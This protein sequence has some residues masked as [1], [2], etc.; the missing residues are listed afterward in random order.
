MNLRR[1]YLIGIGAIVVQLLFTAWGFAQVGFDAQVPTHWGADGQ[2]NGYGAAWW[3]FTLAPAISAG[4][5]LMFG[6]IP[7]IE[8]RRENLRLSASAYRQIGVATVALM[9]LLQAGLIL[10]GTGREVPMTLL[11]GIGIGGLFMETHPDPANAM[12]DGPNAVP[13][14]HMRALLEQLVAI[15]RVI[16]SQALLENDF[17]C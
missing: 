15:D 9:T 12:S 2:V 5:L 14:K 6:A 13:L 17:S 10:A 8:P 3:G 1:L 16:K 4:L 11:I 7:R